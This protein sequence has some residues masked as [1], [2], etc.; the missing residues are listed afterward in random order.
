VSTSELA[1][2]EAFYARDP[3][4]VARDLL[5]M[6]LVRLLD[7]KRLTGTVVEAEAYLSEGDPA[8]HSHR[9]RTP[10][11]GSMFERPGTAYVYAIHGRWCLNVSTEAEGVAS[12]VLLRA[13]EP[14]SGLDAMRTRRGGRK[15]RD[16]LSGPAK[17]CE[18]LAVARHFDGHDLTAGHTLWIEPPRTPPPD[19]EVVACPRIGVTSAKDLPLRFCIAGSP[20]LSKPAPAP[21]A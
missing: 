1:L 9:G 8:A 14:L 17:L 2:P 4:T 15:D 19:L 3:R 20:W 16:L 6:S 5:G 13:L 10:R 12:A 18:A 21:T 7:G 11:N